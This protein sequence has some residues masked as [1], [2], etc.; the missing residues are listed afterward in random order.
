[1]KGS[2]SVFNYIHLLYYQCHNINPNR[3]ESYTDSLI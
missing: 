1:M 3:G 2:E